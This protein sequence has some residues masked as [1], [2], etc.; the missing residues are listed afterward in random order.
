MGL[1]FAQSCIA[2]IPD[3]PAPGVIFKDVT[4]IAANSVALASVLDAIAGHFN[5]QN[6][7]HIAGIEARG[8]IFGAA[9]AAHLGIGFIPIRKSGKLPRETHRREYALEYGVD[10]IEIHTDAVGAGD[11]VLVIDDVLAT[12]GTAC[13]AIALVE[14]CDATAVGLAVLLNLAFL[15]GAQ[16]VG[17]AFPS[18]D[19]FTVFPEA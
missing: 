8:F 12:G 4:P 7:T 1:E 17:A 10:A 6:I 16:K 15:G 13:A 11:R 2:Q 18:V 3:Y 9:L 19:V 14:Q 5:D